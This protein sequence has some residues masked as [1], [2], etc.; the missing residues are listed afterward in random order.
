MAIV[1]TRPT[2]SPALRASGLLAQMPEKVDSRG[3]APKGHTR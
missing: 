2:L 3:R 1:A